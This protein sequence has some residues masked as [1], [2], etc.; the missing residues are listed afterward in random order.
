MTSTTYTGYVG[1]YTK[2]DSQGIYSFQLE[3]DQIKNIELAA[4]LE[5]PT[6]LTISSSQSHLYAVMKEGNLGG[7]A[8]Y[9]LDSRQNGLT[10]LNK[11][12]SPGASPCHV[13]LD[14]KSQ[15][16]LSANY[17]KGTV[18]YYSLLQNGEI[19]NLLTSTEIH[20]SGPHERQEKPHTHFAG[21][22]PDEKYVV[23]VDLGTDEIILF[24]R[25][26]DK[27]TK[28][29]TLATQPGSGP[30]HI[31]FH[32]NGKWAYCMTELS[33]EIIALQYD[34]EKGELKETTYYKTIPEDFSE[35]NQGSA[36]HLSQDGKFLYAGNRGHNSIA[37]FAIAE[38][39]LHLT[40]VAHTSTYGDW[41]RDFVLDPT[42]EYLI[43]ANER[44]NNLTLF[45]RE[46]ESGLLQLLQQNV[47]VPEPVCVKFSP[48]QP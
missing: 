24:R 41:P 34:A 29:F 26:G 31:T 6:Y 40:F 44:S 39:R 30:R 16:L 47:P 42:E 14:Q 10:L 12:L 1:T 35:N 46:A 11:H 25:D 5:N 8:A 27:L 32:P 36:I 19:K 45:K 7:V 13:S 38:D 18:D 20:G 3:D 37:I 22:T 28:H 15:Y 43:A 2:K 33:S 48:Q 17:H 23:A 4:K 9:E 21:L